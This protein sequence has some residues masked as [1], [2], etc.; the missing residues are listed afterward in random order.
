M[1]NLILENLWNFCKNLYF[2]F[3]KIT[4]GDFWT[5]QAWNKRL[6][7]W[8]FKVHNFYY[9]LSG[10]YFYIVIFVIIFYFSP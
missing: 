7:L 3:C 5:I 6:F 4:L 2:V 1:K 10:N 9:S 8:Y